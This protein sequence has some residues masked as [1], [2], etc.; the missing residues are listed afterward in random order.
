M[1]KKT[2]LTPVEKAAFVAAADALD[3][4]SQWHRQTAQQFNNQEREHH[5]KV[6]LELAN[7]AELY[8]NEAETT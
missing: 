4:R 2:Q 7:M 8:R 3:Q 1:A 5:E 6:S